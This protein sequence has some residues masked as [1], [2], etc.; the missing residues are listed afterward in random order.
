[1]IAPRAAL[2]FLALGLLALLGAEVA[3]GIGGADVQPPRAPP[4]LGGPPRSP[5]PDH[6]ATQIAT[7]LERPLF[8]PDRRAG[9]AAAGPARGAD[10]PIR[11]SGIIVER[12]GRT[13]IFV[14]GGRTVTAREGGE[15]AGFKVK[16]IEIGKV[17][18]E[19]PRGQQ[20]L[21]PSFDQSGGA[22]ARAAADVQAA[23]QIAPGAGGRR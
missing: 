16:L 14:T 3:R 5:A 9:V 8:A 20:I 4:G 12:S 21:R 22:G 23:P 18:V 10:E 17:T 1:M 15:V 2:A 13:G 7:M 11:L 19:G 6:S